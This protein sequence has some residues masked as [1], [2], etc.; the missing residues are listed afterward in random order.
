MKL[1]AH[2]PRQEVKVERSFTCLPAGCQPEAW[3]TLLHTFAPCL[4][5]SWQPG[6]GICV[7]M[8]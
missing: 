6:E 8:G 7:Y 4:C 1:A 3:G 5:M 2:Q